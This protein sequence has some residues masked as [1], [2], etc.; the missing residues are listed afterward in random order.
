MALTG[1]CMSRQSHI[2]LYVSLRTLDVRHET[3]T[4]LALIMFDSS[5]LTCTEKLMFIV[6]L[7]A[8]WA[9]YSHGTYPPFIPFDYL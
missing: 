3:E 6:D 4:S 2:R 9:D 8:I 1:L 7:K 5:R